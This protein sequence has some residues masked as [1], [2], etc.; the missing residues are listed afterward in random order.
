MT[1]VDRVD[2]ELSLDVLCAVIYQARE[3]AQRDHGARRWLEAVARRCIAETGG[4]EIS[5]ADIAWAALS[6]MWESGEDGRGEAETGRRGKSIP[7]GIGGRTLL[8]TVGRRNELAERG[9]ER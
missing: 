1:A 6:V 3:D 2:P 7:R 4:S 5:T 8:A 9:L